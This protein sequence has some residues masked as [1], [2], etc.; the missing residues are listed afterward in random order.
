MCLKQRH[1]LWGA[2]SVLLGRRGQRAQT[3]P[4]QR[5]LCDRPCGRAMEGRAPWQ[6]HPQTQELARLREG[7]GGWGQR[8]QREGEGGRGKK[9]QEPRRGQRGGLDSWGGHSGWGRPHLGSAQNTQRCAHR[10]CPPAG[11]G[12][13][14]CEITWSKAPL[15]SELRWGRGERGSLSPANLLSS[16]PASRRAGRGGARA[17]KAGGPPR[18]PG[19][20]GPQPG[21]S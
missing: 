6:Q 2:C 15:R 16:P 7:G 12:F 9:G 10:L 14:V 17:A 1:A 11:L 18:P 13:P 3:R 8:R 21:G 4:T 5:D 20:H 19:R